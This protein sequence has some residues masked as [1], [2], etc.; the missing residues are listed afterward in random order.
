[1]PPKAKVPKKKAVDEA[2]KKEGSSQKVDDVEGIKAE[3]AAF[4]AQLGLAGSGGDAGFDDSDFRPEKAREKLTDAQKKKRAKDQSKSQ[5]SKQVEK[6]RSAPIKAPG[7]RQEKGV[8]AQ[9]R[10]PDSGSQEG[11]ERV[12]E[13][14]WNAGVG[15]RPGE[16]P[17]T[18][19]S[20]YLL[21]H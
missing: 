2:S 21:P 11:D 6:K 1:M 18:H 17:I 14:T 3:V 9:N 20:S 4:A 7:A 15:P 13:R 10:R 12:K 5:D 8:N 16:N 19:L